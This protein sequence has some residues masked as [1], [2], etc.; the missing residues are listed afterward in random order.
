MRS[1]VTATATPA[2][3]GLPGWPVEVPGVV[4]AYG[5]AQDWITE[6]GDAASAADLNGDATRCSSR[7]RSGS[8][9]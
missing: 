7:S 5:T 1:G 9:R 2:A 3:P 8:P 4:G 6:G